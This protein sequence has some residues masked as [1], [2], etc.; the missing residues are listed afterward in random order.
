MQNFSDIP[1]SETIANSRQ[2]LL[3]ND[4]TVMSCSSGTSF[5]TTN[6]VVGMFCLRTDEWKLYQLK[7]L[8][9]TWKLIF[10]LTKTATNKEYVDTQDAL[11]VNKAG[12]TITGTLTVPSVLNINAQDAVSKGGIIRLRGAG[13]Y[14]DKY[15]ENVGNVLNI[16]DGTTALFSVDFTNFRVLVNGYPVWHQANDGSG[17]GLDADLLD[18][19]HASAFSLASHT[20]TMPQFAVLTGSIAHG[21][22]IPLPAGFTQAECKWTVSPNTMDDTAVGNKQHGIRCWADANRLVNCQMRN[23]EYN[24]YQNGTANYII[25]GVK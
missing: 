1:S 3:D 17:S 13:S 16:T 10:D 25:V 4:R 12:D 5:P 7:D 2:K 23:N 24:T 11:K 15:I 9:P 19:Q 20:H 21:G 8:I 6:L 18:G 22:T 14:S